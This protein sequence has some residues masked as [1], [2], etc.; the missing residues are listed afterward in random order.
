[1]NHLFDVEV[2]E[3]YGLNEAIMIR[4]I[5]YW[6]QFLHNGQP[7]E[8]WSSIKNLAAFFPFWSKSQV[9]KILKSL[10]KQKILTIIH[11]KEGFTCNIQL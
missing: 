1:M 7:D 6:R 3:K 11:K 5:V 2:A 10:I 4:Y 8:S 9:E